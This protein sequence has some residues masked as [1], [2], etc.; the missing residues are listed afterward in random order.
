M[1]RV[2]CLIIGSGYIHPSIEK[3]YFDVQSQFRPDT[4]HQRIE[5]QRIQVGIFSIVVAGKVST[6][7]KAD[8][9]RFSAF[10]VIRLLRCHHRHSRPNTD[11]NKTKRRDGIGA[12]QQ[13]ENPKDGIQAAEHNNRGAEITDIHLAILQQE[14]LETIEA[15]CVIHGNSSY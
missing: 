1:E 3:R 4:I 9:H 15:E 7:P 6:H 2:K 12:K 8:R 14:A 11:H 13:I 10:F 5:R